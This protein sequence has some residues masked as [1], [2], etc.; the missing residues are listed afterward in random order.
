MCVNI[1]LLYVNGVEELYGFALL[2]LCCDEGG[3]KLFVVVPLM[4]FNNGGINEM[5]FR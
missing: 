2:K 4:N 1:C 5:F 3:V